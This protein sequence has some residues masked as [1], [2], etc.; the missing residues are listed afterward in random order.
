VYD[1]AVRDDPSMPLAAVCSHCLAHRVE[2]TPQFLLEA[3]AG[4]RRVQ[5]DC[6]EDIM[7][8]GIP[9]DVE[10]ARCPK[11]H[12]KAGVIAVS[13]EIAKRFGRV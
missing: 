1:L 11:C 9:V 7:F 12:G 3:C 10:V 8:P 2:L 13:L 5:I 4:Q 6:G